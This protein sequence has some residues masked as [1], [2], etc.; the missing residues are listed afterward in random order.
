MNTR[1][2]S[3]SS[4]MIFSLCL[5]AALTLFLNEPRAQNSGTDNTQAVTSPGLTQVESKYVCMVTNQLYD[6]EQIP[7]AVDGKTY[8]GCCH[9]CEAKLKEDPA[10]RT[11]IDPVSGK[12]V[13]KSTA[14][15]GAAED[16]KVYYFES[17][18][19][20]RAFGNSTNQ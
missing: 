1:I 19:D 16:G 12:E 7:V 13:D 5:I 18:E 4:L 9:M 20:L 15:I 14:V 3:I 10:S 11:A 8:Y 17:P 6:K 2:F